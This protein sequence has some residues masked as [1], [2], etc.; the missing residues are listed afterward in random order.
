MDWDKGFSAEYY[1]RRIDPQSWRD[2]ERLE[3][4][5]GSVTREAE[6][7]RE[8]AT[9]E[10]KNYDRSAERW[11]RIYLDAK[12]GE[13]SAHVPL[14]TGLA[15]SPGDELDGVIRTNTI[16]CYSV[17]K[18]AADVLLER[19]WY[20]PAGMDGGIILRQLLAVTPAP[21]QV[22]E[23][24]PTL[25]QAVIA[26]DGES[27]LSMVD[28]V[29]TAMDWRL[30]ISGDGTIWAG[31]K[32]DEASAIF[33]PLEHDSIE[34][35]I[36]LEFDWYAAP[37]VFRA[38]SGDLVGVARDD[39]RR[40]PLSTVNRGRE[41][42]L[43]E[44]GVDLASG[45]T[46]AEYALRRLRE[47]QTIATTA[48]YTRRFRPDVMVGDKVDLRYPEQGLVGLYQVTAQTIEL[49]YGAKT[50]ESVKG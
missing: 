3:I 6:D 1:V 25:A 35:E 34:P 38:V 36:E 40:S 47:E 12:Q 32:S 20:A 2:L 31:P 4:I 13:E 50:S 41:V 10:V 9:F 42:W 24:A 8:S 48:D 44:S 19:G 37:N 14:F 11:V 23:D 39:D 28:K 21:L 29:L 43:E 46:I 17:L 27:N 22:A 30:R 18:P 7:L 26:E 49:G 33:D 45:E 15:T 16:T 5:S